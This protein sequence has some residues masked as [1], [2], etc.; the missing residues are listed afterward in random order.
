MQKCIIGFPLIDVAHNA[1][2]IAERVMNVLVSYELDKRIIAVTLDNV[3]ANNVAIELMRPSLSGF[4]EKLFHVRCGCHIIN[5][6]VKEGIDHVHRSIDNIRKCI[7]FFCL[8]VAVEL[9]LLRMFAG[10]TTR[11]RGNL[12]LTK[13]IVGIQHTRC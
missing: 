2:N 12:E 8:A 7:V 13:N 3:S 10:C 11:G 4:H 5:L 1:R 6:I 9:L